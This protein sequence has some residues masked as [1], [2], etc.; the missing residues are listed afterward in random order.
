[1]LSSGIMTCSM[2]SVQP[3]TYHLI[4]RYSIIPPST[5]LLS[6]Y[7][8]PKV[9]IW[10]VL[11][12]PST[13]RV[14]TSQI[15]MYSV[16]T[17]YRKHDKSMYFRLKVQTF[18]SHT[19]MYQYVLSTYF[20]AYSCMCSC[21]SC[22][23]MLGLDTSRH[24]R[25]SKKVNEHPGSA[26]VEEDQYRIESVALAGSNFNVTCENGI[27]YSSL[28]AMLNRRSMMCSVSWCNCNIPCYACIY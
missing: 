6:T 8:L 9:R 22:V 10:Y 2:Y 19:S 28:V 4:P 23:S 27:H 1:M 20:C 5:A 7:F 14:S 18:V 16:R 21:A 12:I 15:S 24:M 11:F 25:P 26:P 17:E 13:Y 3:G